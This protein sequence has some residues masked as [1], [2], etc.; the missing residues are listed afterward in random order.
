MDLRRF[1]IFG[2]FL[3]F[4]PPGGPFRVQGRQD[5]MRGESRARID[6][7]RGP[8]TDC[9]WISGSDMSR[10]KPPTSC[11]YPPV[12]GPRNSRPLL[13]DR[14]FDLDIFLR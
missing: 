9:E 12:R 11:F 2:G 7:G 8:E 10:P 14:S 13:G 3:Q 5:L 6:S 1:S 4:Q